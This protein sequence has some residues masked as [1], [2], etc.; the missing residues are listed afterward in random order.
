LS[1]K[2]CKKHILHLKHWLFKGTNPF[3]VKFIFTT[4]LLVK[5]TALNVLVIISHP[6]MKTLARQILIATGKWE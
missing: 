1:R 3:G 6:K 2:D 4:D 5:L